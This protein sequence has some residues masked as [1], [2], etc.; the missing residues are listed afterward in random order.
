MLAAQVGIN[1][2]GKYRLVT[3]HL[4][5]LAN[6]GTA[7]QQMG[8]KTVAESVRAYLLSYSCFGGQVPDDMKDHH[9]CQPTAF[10]IEENDIFKG[11]VHRHQP[12][13]TEIYAYKL[14]RLVAY[15]DQTLFVPFAYHTDKT[16]VKEKVAQSKCYQLRDTQPATVKGLYHCL[17]AM[18]ERIAQVDSGKYCL[19]LLER[20]HIGK[21]AAYFR[22]VDEFRWESLYTVVD[23]QV[24]KKTAHTTEHPRLCAFACSMVVKRSEERFYMFAS[25]L[26]RIV[27]AESFTHV[28]AHIPQVT[29]IGLDGI[30]GEFFLQFYIISVILQLFFPTHSSKLLFLFQIKKPFPGNTLTKMNYTELTIAT[31][32]QEAAEI[33]VALLSDYPFDSFSDTDSDELKAYIREED[34]AG[35][36]DEVEQLLLESGFGFT[37]ASIEQQNWN[38]IWESNFEPINVEGKCLIRAPFHESDASCAQEVVIMPKMSFGTGHHATTYL[39]V[40]EIMENEFD[41]LS[42]LDMGSGTGVLAILTAKRGAAHTDA[43]DIDEWARENATENIAANGVHGKVTPLLGDASLLGE[44]IYDFI[45]ANI[46]RNIL[47]SD[48]ERY[49]RSMKAGGYIIFSGILEADISAINDKA[50]SLGL[51]PTGRRTREGWAA[52]RF[53]LKCS[54]T[55]AAKI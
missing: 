5:Y 6:V 21:F 38:E 15:R 23:K 18:P 44:N 10:I 8:G 22:R 47:L 45:L 25:D 48:M 30:I 28:T 4:L 37:A 46:N 39:M 49:V 55:P 17:V 16:V 42:G 31:A 1:L 53:V 51:T 41:R 40:A 7:L 33:A 2:G 52:L 26:L 11:R 3:E 24:I 14:H 29:Q 19:Y 20:E 13:L 50:I 9:T 12:A 36:K 54:D 43:I 32:S 27:D 34:F 35:C